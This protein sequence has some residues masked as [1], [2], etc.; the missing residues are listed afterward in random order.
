MTAPDTAISQSI[1]PDNTDT[2]PAPAASAANSKTQA[3]MMGQQ[4][5]RAASETRTSEE[6]E[7]HALKILAQT[8]N[9]AGSLIYYP[10]QDGNMFLRHR[11]LHKGG[12]FDQDLQDA[13]YALASKTRQ[14]SQLSKKS[15]ALQ[16]LD[17]KSGVAK[18]LKLLACPYLLPAAIARLSDTPAEQHYGVMLV[19]LNL[20]DQPAQPYEMLLEMFSA[21]LSSIAGHRLL[22]ILPQEDQQRWQHGAGLMQ[23]LLELEDSDQAIEFCAETLRSV[24]GA[25]ALALAVIYQ[26]ETGQDKILQTSLVPDRFSL[27]GRTYRSRLSQHIRT[28][29]VQALLDPDRV[30]ELDALTQLKTRLNLAHCV[31]WQSDIMQPKQMHGAVNPEEQAQPSHATRLAIL[32]FTEDKSRLN[33]QISL[34]GALPV[35]AYAHLLAI[36]DRADK[37]SDWQQSRR[38]VQRWVKTN[39]LQ[40]AGIAG[41]IMALAFLPLPYHMPAD[42]VLEPESRHLL[43]S[44]FEAELQENLVK[45]G[46]TIAEGAVLARLD[47][48][49]M[50][51]QLAARQ[52]ELQRFRQRY[53][54]YLATGPVSEAENA[55]LEAEKTALDITYLEEKIASAA[56]TSPLSGVVLT[57]KIDEAVG[58]RLL[59]GAP[60]FEIAPLARITAELAIAQEDIRFLRTGSE[61][62]ISFDAYPGEDWRGTIRQMRP[63][64]GLQQGQHV[65][66]VEASLDNQDNRL[67]P[68]MK[69]RAKIASGHRPLLWQIFRKPWERLRK[70][71]G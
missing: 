55:R 45:Q 22:P 29:F 71:L 50:D 49:L 39:P 2:T 63:Q 56:I 58:K 9:A 53:Q 31:F 35:P 16:D 62:K 14:Q 3:M 41:V 52:A 40:A 26:D 60:L 19:M 12:D 30:S 69:G 20:S 33:A 25:D 13:C 6:I 7:K 59:L 17:A 42:T 5:L 34:L 10:D 27:A 24:V 36:K 47:T 28:G 32:A 57:S 15:F 64:S 70:W 44:P 43:Y 1:D 48:Q 65:F 51:L 46:D 68:G 23:R 38:A 54:R 67:Y 4:L 8:M 61:V 37:A 11:L 18:Q 21:S 66:T